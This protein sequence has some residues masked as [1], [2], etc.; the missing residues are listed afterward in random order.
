MKLKSELYKDEQDELANKIIEILELDNDNSIT[1]YELDKDSK[2]QEKIMTLAPD[3]RKYFTYT[4]IMG[5]KVELKRPWLSIIK[6]ITSI[7]YKL[8]VCDYGL[9]VNDKIVRTKR[10]YFIK[11]S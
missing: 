10:Y 8:L 5:V 3:I 4:C 11:I 9:K 1:L 6:H 7:K 2:K